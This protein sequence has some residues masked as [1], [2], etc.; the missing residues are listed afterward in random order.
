M[1]LLLSFVELCWL[2]LVFQKYDYRGH[3]VDTAPKEVCIFSFMPVGK[4][5]EV[6]KFAFVFKGDDG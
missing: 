6:Y 5:L 3:K 4:V 2:L 1:P